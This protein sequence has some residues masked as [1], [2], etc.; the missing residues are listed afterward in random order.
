MNDSQ[1]TPTRQTWLIIFGALAFSVVMYCVLG[2][3]TEQHP[4]RVN[5]AS[6][7]QMRPFLIGAAVVMLVISVA[8]IRFRVDGKIG[9]EGRDLA[10]SPEQFQTDSL[11]ALALSEACAILGLLLFF[12]GAPLRELA[13][14]AAG[15]LLVDFAFILPR[16]LQFW[17]AHDKR[18]GL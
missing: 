15:T 11:V 9:G 12:L 8:W 14:F 6:V 2:F 1:V 7:A 17:A 4:R 3:I 18:S 5:P 16:G 13:M 10:M